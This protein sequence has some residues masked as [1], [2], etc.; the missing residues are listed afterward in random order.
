MITQKD[1]D[2][3]QDVLE[4]I[5]TNLE[6]DRRNT[7]VI[8]ALRLAL[9]VETLNSKVDARTEFEAPMDPVD[10]L[11]A[12]RCALFTGQ[13]SS[14]KTRAQ[15]AFR[16]LTRF[17]ADVYLLDVWATANDQQHALRSGS[18][19]EEQRYTVVLGYSDDHFFDGNTPDE[20]R[21]LAVK[22]LNNG[23]LP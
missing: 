15:E 2:Y 16:R 6:E 11:E 9:A 22:A 8:D 18:P 12:I 20:A 1:I 3:V 21:A 23:D 19:D 5:P 7:R 14:A 4:G 10:Q 13:K 17:V